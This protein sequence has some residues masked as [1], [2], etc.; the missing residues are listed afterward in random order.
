MDGLLQFLSL[1][2]A[3]SCVEQET[4]GVGQVQG[5]T[6][7]L[8][9]SVHRTARGLGAADPQPGPLLEVCGG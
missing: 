6:V 8:P 7:A 2:P 5:V 1:V 4:V 3:V 9:A